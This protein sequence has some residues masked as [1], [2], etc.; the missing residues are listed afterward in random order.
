MKR[1][2]EV[3]EM[4][5]WGSRKKGT[6]MDGDPVLG[7]RYDTGSKTC[8]YLVEAPVFLGSSITHFD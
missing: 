7:K 4:T 1:I 2:E 5:V 8:S 3:K 6:T